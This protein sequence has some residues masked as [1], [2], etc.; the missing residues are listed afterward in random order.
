MGEKGIAFSFEA[1]L[2]LIFLALIIIYSGN[3]EQE[4]SSAEILILQKSND[5]LKIWAKQGIPGEK[6]MAEDFLLAFPQH[7]GKIIINKKETKIGREGKQA[8]STGFSFFSAN[9]EKKEITL[10]V[11][12]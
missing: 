2:S 6:E 11:F 12:Y 9:L 1:A 3:Q 5:L 4:E 10:I 8:I 7:Y